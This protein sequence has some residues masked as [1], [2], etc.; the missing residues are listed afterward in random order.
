MGLIVRTQ[1]CVAI[2]LFY[3]R[4]TYYRLKVRVVVMYRYAKC[5]CG[6][7]RYIV[8]VNGGK[9]KQQK[10]KMKAWKFFKY[11]FDF[12]ELASLIME[13]ICVVTIK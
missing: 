11:L 5:G 3:S 10:R 13:N 2:R 9:R 8:V 7:K 1:E 6:R 4:Q 12:L